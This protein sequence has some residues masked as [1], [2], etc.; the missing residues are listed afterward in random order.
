[1][2]KKSKA[3]QTRPKKLIRRTCSFSLCFAICCRPEIGM[4]PLLAL[5]ACSLILAHEFIVARLVI[6]KQWKWGRESRSSRQNESKRFCLANY[7]NN[8]NEPKLD[9]EI[10]PS[11]PPIELSTSLQIIRCPSPSCYILTQTSNGA[12]T[13][14]KRS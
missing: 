13:T 5:G 6:W 9:L 10:A 11:S 12:Y 2:E 8:Y 1:M 4:S 3:A 14:E 7:S